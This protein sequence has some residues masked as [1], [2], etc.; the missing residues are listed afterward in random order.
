MSYTARWSYLLSLCLFL[1][2]SA[3]FPW[4]MHWQWLHKKY[5]DQFLKVVFICF[6][7]NT[8]YGSNHICETSKHW[9]NINERSTNFPRECQNWQQGKIFASNYLLVDWLQSHDACRESLH[10]ASHRPPRQQIRQT[11]FVRVSQTHLVFLRMLLIYSGSKHFFH[12]LC[13]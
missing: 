3:V 9:N 1:H 4:S 11:R 7:Q 13:L 12:Y 8:D 10:P 2:L 6:R 5:W